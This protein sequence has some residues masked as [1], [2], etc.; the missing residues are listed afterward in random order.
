MQRVV[1]IGCGIVGAMI[2]YE[3]SRF[4]QFEIHVL[5]QQ[6]PA[7][8]STG[9]ALGVL[10]GIIS[11]KLK[12]RA[13]HLREAS[14][15]R[16]E[17][18]IPEL[19]QATGRTL[20]YNRQG[21]LSLCFDPDELPKWH[22]VKA[23]RQSQG[24]ELAL[25]SPDQVKAACP[26]LDTS[27]IQA[28]I[29]SPQDRQLDPTALTLA[30]VTAAQQQGVTFQQNCHVMGL[31]WADDA[32]TCVGVQTSPEILPADWVVLAAGL[33]SA[34]LTQASTAP[35]GLIPV[36]GQA[37]QIRVS[38]PLGHRS[39]QPSITG[40]DIHLVPLGQQEYWVGAT[41]EFPPVDAA[42]WP[43]WQPEA[44]ALEPVLAGAIAYCPALAQAE[45]LQT[46]SGLRPRP[47]AKPA[48][49][50]ERLAHSPNVILATGHYRNGVLLAPATAQQVIGLLMQG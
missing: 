24:W 29:Y 10:M 17:T 34:A 39:F 8:G 18:L 33:G 13:W 5:D 47:Q 45:I 25:W 14:L 37:M 41:V 4:P 38:E 48:P 26:H 49:V 21:I 19:E 15:Q 36:L 3:L 23:I 50:I 31:V 30:L 43:T 12:G 16:Y 27:V 42:D 22:Q 44:G 11:H 1:V 6:P 2:A 35:L 46:W 32:V 7:Q 20:P 28:G 9:A 40:A